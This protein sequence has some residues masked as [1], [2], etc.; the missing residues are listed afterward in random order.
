[1]KEDFRQKILTNNL[2]QTLEGDDI[3]SNSEDIIKEKLE[4]VQTGLISLFSDYNKNNNYKVKISD[5][6]LVDDSFRFV[7]LRLKLI[8]SD[9]SNKHSNF[10]T[11]QK[12]YT[13]F[14]SDSSSKEK[15][16]SNLIEEIYEFI[17]S[18]P[19]I[20]F[21]IFFEI[22]IDPSI[23][24]YDYIN[25]GNEIKTSILN[26]YF[27]TKKWVIVK[28]SKKFNLY[29]EDNSKN[30]YALAC[31][32]ISLTYIQ[33]TA[34]YKSITD[35]CDSELIDEK[36]FIILH[37]ESINQTICGDIDKFYDYMSS[38]GK[39]QWISL[40][41]KI[42]E[43]FKEDDTCFDTAMYDD[44]TNIY[45]Y[46]KSDIFNKI[47]I[48][49][50]DRDKLYCFPRKSLLNELNDRNRTYYECEYQ[51]GDGTYGLNP[52]RDYRRNPIELVKV[53]ADMMFVFKYSQFKNALTSNS[54][55]FKIKKERKSLP[56]VSVAYVNGETGSGV[57]GAHC[58]EGTRDYIYSI[59]A[60]PL[61]NSSEMISSNSLS[62]FS[63]FYDM[64]QIQF[65]LIRISSNKYHIVPTI[66]NEFMRSCI[67][68]F[69]SSNEKKFN[70]NEKNEEYEDPILIS[71]DENI[72]NEIVYKIVEKAP[73]TE[74]TKIEKEVLELYNDVKEN[75]IKRKTDAFN[76]KYAEMFEMS[77]YVIPYIIKDFVDTGSGYYKI[78]KNY[79]SH[80]F[81]NE[82]DVNPN[83]IYNN[84]Y[85]N[86]EVNLLIWIA[87][88]IVSQMLSEEEPLSYMVSEMNASD[89]TQ[90]YLL[91]IKDRIKNEEIDV[92]INT[93]IK[94]LLEDIKSD[95]I[96][97]E[98]MLED[99]IYD[100]HYDKDILIEFYEEMSKYPVFDDSNESERKE[101][102]MI[103]DYINFFN[104]FEKLMKE[105]INDQTISRG[106]IRDIARSNKS[107]DED[108]EYK[109]SDFY[110]YDE[111]IYELQEL[112]KYGYMSERTKKYM[113][114][115]YHLNIRGEN[116]NDDI[117][118]MFD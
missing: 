61:N 41:P 112:L 89:I 50:L 15:E 17:K 48:K 75:S 1:M 7:Q 88:R 14:I 40:P 56:L 31:G 90:E 43:Y 57:G 28:S 77:N 20:T 74:L 118:M 29:D 107:E 60:E 80:M 34:L 81:L 68:K 26:K 49:D 73:L 11:S 82:Q 30:N 37:N 106:K 64:K 63:S 58:Q 116:E 54:I 47:I 39:K 109:K 113:N 5:D 8:Y 42:S 96:D 66:E 105:L 52:S 115:V 95:Y 76:E 86:M 91:V 83:L 32:G 100:V 36:N 35:S 18:K 33:N 101:N 23:S 94:N 97:S 27:L 110:R 44:D 62:V 99:R 70:L 79:M 114:E 13:I 84:S 22:D 85:R 25:E 59:E 51:R 21:R 45:D 46:Y 4:I 3:I 111:F 93:Q 78:Y 38:N 102:E 2:S 98:D 10:K 71:T 117:E 53:A 16:I 6:N 12:E 92:K 72:L 67:A 87:M 24:T 69:I 104:D 55:F 9:W 108:I 103:D 19:Y 65:S